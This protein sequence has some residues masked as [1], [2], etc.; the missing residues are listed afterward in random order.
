MQEPVTAAGAEPHL[1]KQSLQ[2]VGLTVADEEYAIDILEIVAVERCENVVQLPRMPESV[3]GLMSIRDEIVPLIELRSK[4]GFDRRRADANTRVV[5]I[6]LDRLTI[7]LVVDSVTRVYRLAGDAVQEAPPM[8]VSIDSRFVRGVLR[9]ADGEILV[10]LDP[11]KIIDAE[12]V[13]EISR[14]RSLAQHYVRAE[15]E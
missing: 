2:V 11:Q 9:L 15:K 7:G 5:V 10:Y 14:A 8:A 1:E 3:A 13:D 6:N 4:F 12:K